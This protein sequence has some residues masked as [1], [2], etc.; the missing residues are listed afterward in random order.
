MEIQLGDQ[1]TDQGFDWEVVTRL[2]AMLGAKDMRARVRRPG[3]PETERD[4]IWPAHVR[5]EIR[6]GS[7]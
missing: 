5:V 1:F 7:S 2:T 3:I 4:M 6:R